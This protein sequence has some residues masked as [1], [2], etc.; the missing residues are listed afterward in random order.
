MNLGWRR[1]K[2]ETLAAGMQVGSP[3][4]FLCTV[5]NL[6]CKQKQYLW[7]PERTP[8]Y[9]AAASSNL[10]AAVRSSRPVQREDVCP[11]GLSQITQP[12]VPRRETRFLGK[13]NGRSP[14]KPVRKS[15][16]EDQPLLLG[17]PRWC[18]ELFSNV[19]VV[20][21]HSSAVGHH[22][23]LPAVCGVSGPLLSVLHPL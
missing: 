3:S 2:R 16:Q 13:G 10:G 8:V 15:S 9:G 12:F 22:G 20:C 6:A 23:Q 21:V 4:C 1:W 19:A 17:C 11:V 14:S 5:S 18:F 7:R